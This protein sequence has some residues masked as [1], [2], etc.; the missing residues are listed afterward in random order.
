MIMVFKSGYRNLNLLSSRSSTVN[1][2]A[3]LHSTRAVAS[4]NRIRGEYH[5]VIIDAPY[6][7]YAGRAGPGT[8][9]NH[10]MTARRLTNRT[11]SQQ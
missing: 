4:L 7:E 5:T 3:L 2:G 10:E 1:V 8:N 6:A 9:I 11:D